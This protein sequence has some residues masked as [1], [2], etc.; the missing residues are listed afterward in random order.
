MSKDSANLYTHVFQGLGSPN[1]VSSALPPQAIPS[2]KKNKKWGEDTMDRLEEIGQRQITKNLVFDEYYR[3]VEGDLAYTDYEMT[4][5][6]LKHVEGIRD[7][8]NIPSSVRHFDIIG[9]V[10]YHL[11]TKYNETKAKFRVD[12]LDEIAVNE[13]DRELTNRLF[14]F[15]KEYFQAELKTRLARNGIFIEQLEQLKTDEQKQQ[16]IQMLEQKKAELATPPEISSAMQTEWKPIAAK[17]ARIT[18]EKDRVVFNLDE[19]ER[20]FFVDRFLTGRYFKHYRI[21]Y[22]YYNIER[23]NTV[24]TFFSEDADL[25]YPQKGEYVGHLTEMGP[26]KVVDNFGHL[27]KEADI[28]LIMNHFDYNGG[29]Q[30]ERNSKKPGFQ[31]MLENNLTEDAK[32]LPHEN[33]YDRKSSLELQS[34]LQVPLGKTTFYDDEGQ[35]Q[36]AADWIPDYDF[37]SNVGVNSVTKYLRRDIDVR[38]DTIR[39]TQAYWKSWQKIGLLYYENDFGR[40]V[41]EWVTDE[42]LDD[43]LKENDIKT[44]KSKSLKEFET[45]MEK[46]TLEPNSIVFTYAPIAY[47]GI[48]LSGRNT[49]LGKDIYLDVGP[50]EIQIKGNSEIYDI[51]L[52]V[53]GIVT[54]SEAK[55]MRPYQ[56]EHNYQM[57]LMHSLTEK[58]IGIFWLF[59]ISLL[60]SDFEGMGDA[61]E[62]LL[63]V[64]DMARDTGLVPIDMSKQNMKDRVGQQFNSMMPQDISFVPQIQQKMELARYYKNLALDSIGITEQNMKTPDQY[65]TAEGIK[66]GQVNSVAQIEHVFEEMDQARLKD[67]EVGLTIAQF[68]EANDKE[69]SFSYMRSDEEQFLIRQVFKDEDFHL[70]K[71][72][73]LPIADSKK[74]KQLEKFKQ[75]IFETNTLSNDLLDIS[76][77]IVSESF[78]TINK[79][80]KESRNDLEKQKQQEQE[81]EQNLLNSRLEAEAEQ[82][83]L[84]RVEKRETQQR[85]LDNNLQTSHIAAVSRVKDRNEE[86]GDVEDVNKVAD[87]YSKERIEG[88]KNKIKKE[89]N[90]SKQELAFAKLKLQMEELK[91][92]KEQNQVQRETNMAKRT[93]DILEV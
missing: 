19:M 93:G 24:E 4:P 3:M 13:Y 48:K 89:D 65:S 37:D 58:E 66:V 71:L 39:V 27:M 51:S 52:P 16:Y 1:Q 44:L 20:Q 15:S 10:A 45:E 46:G 75:Y 87:R 47:K 34:A 60:P 30:G 81:Y 78:Q 42:L 73:L 2:Y 35:Q 77:I 62:T 86:D 9:G 22:D 7:K 92:Q 56:I 32:M 80:L 59:D 72:G 43:F 67:L 61:R 76:Q 12:F 63:N 91:V 69:I 6:I 90:K 11:A 18:L 70:R 83:E 53:T 64:L 33:Y 8:A 55:K 88:E 25:K 74:R 31:K 29:G 28:K 82:K 21:G 14:N 84:D 50:M 49:I 38:E 54:N 5:E 23:W 79:V 85:E 36:E 57:N 41:T 26:F 17:W 40:A 68:C